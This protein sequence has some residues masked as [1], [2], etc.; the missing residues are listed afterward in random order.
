M[1]PERWCSIIN[2]ITA[3][4]R[5][6]VPSSRISSLPTSFLLPRRCFG[7]E[8]DKLKPCHSPGG[9]ALNPAS[10][11]PVPPPHNWGGN[12][13][14]FT[15]ERLVSPAAPREQEMPRGWLLGCLREGAEGGQRLPPP[16]HQ[17]FMYFLL[18]PCCQKKNPAQPIFRS[19]EGWDAE[20][21]QRDGLSLDAGH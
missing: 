14:T 21:L 3:S 2:P 1:K 17:L 11:L 20:R 13:S 9:P 5:S 19:G 10:L 6:P 12:N 18:F 15:R 4:F 7:R 8:T 16:R